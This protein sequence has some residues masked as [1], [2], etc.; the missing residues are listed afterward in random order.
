MY[1]K[2]HTCTRNTNL[3]RKVKTGPRKY[4]I[5]PEMPWYRNYR[6]VPESTNL[7]QELPIGTQI[8]PCV[9]K[10]LISTKKLRFLP[11]SNT[12]YLKVII[13]IKST[14]LKQKV[15]T[16]TIKYFF[17]QKVKIKNRNFQFLPTNLGL[18]KKN[19]KNKKIK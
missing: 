17:F 15:F 14:N 5:V 4:L 11:K 6:I 12:Q 13:R 10:I 16:C 7:H 3:H 8:N 18:L 2:L 1:W 9:P 19:K